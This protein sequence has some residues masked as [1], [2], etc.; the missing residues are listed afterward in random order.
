MANGITVVIPVRNEERNIGSCLDGLRFAQA[1]F[2][3]DSGSTDN[4]VTIAESRG[5]T[6]T[7]FKYSGGYPKKKNWA[8]ENLPIDSS[9]ILIV[10]ADERITEELAEEIVAAVEHHDCSGYYIPRRFMFMGKWIRHC[11]YYPSYVLRLFRKGLG[12]YEVPLGSQ[13]ELNSGDVEIHEGVILNGKAGYLQSDMLHLAYPDIFTWIEKHNRYSD[14]EARSRQGLY[15][16]STQVIKARLFGDA[17]ERKRW[18]QRA[19]S[20]L[21]AGPTL[22]FLYHYIVKLGF[23]DGY[24][25]YVMCRLLGQY[26]FWSRAKRIQPVST[27]DPP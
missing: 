25:G 27:G 6:V 11:G 21:P 17:D 3:V 19:S 14:W 18:V 22:R 7:Q 10:D 9:W 1:I 15:E 13:T 8:L 2:V 23:M 12:Q 4:T 24:P 16:G 20:E 5:A 26:E